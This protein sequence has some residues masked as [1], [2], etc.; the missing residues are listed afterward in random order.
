IPQ[1]SPPLPPP[2]ISRFTRYAAPVRLPPRPP[3]S[4]TLRLL[5]SPRRVSPDCP[6]HHSSV[7]CP[8]PRRIERVL[9]SITSPL[10]RPSPHFG[11]VGIRIMDFE[12]CSGFTRVTARWIARPPE[13]GFVTR[14]RAV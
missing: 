11:R 9:V 1:K 7:L 2:G 4:A 5:S 12:A 8:L 6:H 3:L 10:T 14:L 13:G